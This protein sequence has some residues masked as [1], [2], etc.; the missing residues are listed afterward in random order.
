MPLLVLLRWSPQGNQNR[1]RVSLGAFCAPA[2]LCVLLLLAS[3]CITDPPGPHVTIEAVSPVSVRSG[4]GSTLHLEVRVRASQNGPPIA[5]RPVEWL[6]PT[7]DTNGT[8]TYSDAQGIARYEH[9]LPTAPGAH[10]IFAIV[11]PTG[12]AVEF[13]VEVTPIS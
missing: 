13:T 6:S 3:G 8:K 12:N 2:A 1:F 7:L 11:Q 5:N 10:R 4:V 9:V